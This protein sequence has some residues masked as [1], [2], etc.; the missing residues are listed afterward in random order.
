MRYFSVARSLTKSGWGFHAPQSHYAICLGCE[1]SFARHLVYAD[2]LDLEDSQVAVP[3]GV[4]CRQ[5]D[6]DDCRQRADPSLL[7]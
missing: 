4:S 7:H 6:R 2:G 3:V 1:V 5:C